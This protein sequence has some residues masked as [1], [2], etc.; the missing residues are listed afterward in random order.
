MNI[1]ECYMLVFK[2]I[3]FVRVF[4]EEYS[5]YDSIRKNIINIVEEVVCNS[6]KMLLSDSEFDVVFYVVIVMFDEVI[7]CL[8]F[9]CRKEWCDNFL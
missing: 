9:F 4:F 8:E 6:E 7:L 3:L 5:D 2:F 1:V